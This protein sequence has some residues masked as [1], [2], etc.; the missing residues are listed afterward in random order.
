MHNRYF[1]KSAAC[2]MVMTAASSACAQTPAE[3][4]AWLQD[5]WKAGADCTFADPLL[6]E[7]QIEWH[8]QFT[9]EELGLKTREAAGKPDHP[10]ALRIEHSARRLK[11]GPEIGNERVWFDGGRWRYGRDY[12][13]FG[14]NP[15]GDP[16]Y[17]DSAVNGQDMW[18][19]TPDVL[20]VSSPS[21]GTTYG[22]Y[23]DPR[24]SQASWEG[25]LR[26]LI[27]AGLGAGKAIQLQLSSVEVIAPGVWR[28]IARS[29]V[30]I[31]VQVDG[32][33]DESA[34]RGR[35]SATTLIGM[36]PSSSEKPGR[37]HTYADWK[38][39]PDLGRPVAGIVEEF[40]A[41][42]HL[43]ERVRLVKVEKLSNTAFEQALATPSVR[44]EDVI[45]GPSKF[46][47]VYDHRPGNRTLTEYAGTATTTTA[48]PNRDST[49]TLWRRIGW[50]S[51]AVMVA[52]L[53]FIRLR[54]Q[55][56]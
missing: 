10:D 29:P 20:Q 32:V 6:V 41:R 37:K 40:D 49:F 8:S 56:S 45:R 55:F 3:L 2:L 53:V 30:G 48:L 46:T 23:G 35:V 47:S 25:Y 16:S 51:A 21:E 42:G 13:L 31:E 34:G 15:K 11:D 33:W 7:Y 27:F 54:K 44:G 50:I 5:E 24:E 19:M 39:S 18:T 4:N 36:P 14:R 28:A 26:K 38:D 1:V 9:P 12:K 22:S 52:A 17:Y 43:V